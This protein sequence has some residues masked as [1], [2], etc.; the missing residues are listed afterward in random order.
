MLKDEARPNLRQSQGA[1]E[2][3]GM[4]ASHAAEPHAFGFGLADL[5]C[6]AAGQLMS[7]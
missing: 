3:Q 2:R 5:P 7:N 6:P 1:P 4:A